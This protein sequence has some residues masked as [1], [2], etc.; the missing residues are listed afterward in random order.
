[1]HRTIHVLDTSDRTSTSSL[2]N[3]CISYIGVQLIAICAVVE[4]KCAIEKSNACTKK[5]I[6]SGQTDDLCAD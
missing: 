1:M 2:V 3:Q 6:N 5:Y 4:S